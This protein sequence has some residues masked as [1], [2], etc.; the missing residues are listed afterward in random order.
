MGVYLSSNPPTAMWM[1]F[2]CGKDYTEKILVDS[3]LCS[4]LI[5]GLLFFPPEKKLPH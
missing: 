4:S 5:K 2:L 3:S 1:T